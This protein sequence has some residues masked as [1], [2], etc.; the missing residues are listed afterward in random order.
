VGDWF[1]KINGIYIAHF[2]LAGSIILF[3]IYRQTCSKVAEKFRFLGLSYG[4][5]P[6]NLLPFYP[7]FEIFMER[8]PMRH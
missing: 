8:Y 4:S 5:I 6:S 3:D 2:R 1:K 7:N